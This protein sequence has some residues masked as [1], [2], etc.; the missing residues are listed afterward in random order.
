VKLIRVC[1]GEIDQRPHTDISQLLNDSD[2]L[3][4]VSHPGAIEAQRRSRRP[5]QELAIQ[6]LPP[7]PAHTYKYP[8]GQLQRGMS[9]VG[10]SNLTGAQWGTR[11]LTGFPVS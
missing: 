3:S 6:E 4:N 11:Q 5:R 2:S 1:A 9:E 10:L 8:A 7:Y